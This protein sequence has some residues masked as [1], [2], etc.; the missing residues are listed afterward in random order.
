MRHNQALANKQQH[1]RQSLKFDDNLFPVIFCRKRILN[2]AFFPLLVIKTEHILFLS[3]LS[4]IHRV[5]SFIYSL[6]GSPISSKDWYGQLY[7]S[8]G[9]P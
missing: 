1:D 7:T 8:Y 4:D 3:H 2:I 5:F 6:L 9:Q